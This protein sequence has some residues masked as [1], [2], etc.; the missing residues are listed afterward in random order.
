MAHNRVGNQETA[1]LDEIRTG[2]L[3][4]SG[5]AVSGAGSSDSLPSHWS[6]LPTR[7]SPCMTGSADLRSSS[8]RQHLPRPSADPVG[9]RASRGGQHRHDGDHHKQPDVAWRLKGRS[10]SSVEVRVMTAIPVNTVAEPFIRLRAI[11]HLEKGYIVIFAAV[12]ATLT[13]LPITPLRSELSKPDA[14][15][16]SSPRTGRGGSSQPTRGRSLQPHVSPR[17][18]RY[19]SSQQPHGGRSAVSHPRPRPPSAVSRLRLR[20]KIDDRAP[21]L[22]PTPKPE[23][24]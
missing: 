17:E 2:L 13:S 22:R 3:K 6:I 12:R 18:L 14:T 11:H 9:N 10:H 19:D 20:R 16:S 15:A 8:G 1:K 23:R 5:R 24:L 21:L 4:L 7:F